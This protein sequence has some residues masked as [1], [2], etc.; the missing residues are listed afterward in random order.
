MF[1]FGYALCCDLQGQAVGVGTISW[2]DCEN[3]T[4]FDPFEDVDVDHQFFAGKA[5]AVYVQS[6]GHFSFQCGHDFLMTP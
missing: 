6:N 2:V 1:G 3:V 4:G 5:M